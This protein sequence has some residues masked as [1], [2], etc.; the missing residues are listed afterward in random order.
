MRKRLS[1]LLA[2]LISGVL[3]AQNDLFFKAKTLFDNGKYS[4]A[5][6]ILNQIFT[7][8][9]ATSEIMYLNAKCSKELFL[10]DAILL[11][12][13]LNEAFPYHEFKD[14]VNKTAVL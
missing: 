14:D 10:T 8:G 4:A 12:N 2:V 13:N 9:N 3:F 1:L 6:S 5:Q 7:S 11:Y